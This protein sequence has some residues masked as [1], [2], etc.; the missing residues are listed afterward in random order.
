[1]VRCFFEHN[2]TA[3]GT[4][5]AH[6][7]ESTYRD[8]LNLYEL[9]NAIKMTIITVATL[10]IGLSFLFIETKEL[11]EARANLKWVQIWQTNLLWL[12][13]SPLPPFETAWQKSDSY[14]FPYRQWEPIW[15][16]QLIRK[17]KEIPVYIKIQIPKADGPPQ[18]KLPEL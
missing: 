3:Y 11:C 8:H 7:P 16:S 18:S 15:N 6:I 17:Y 12:M 2:T 5:M 1:M 4:N 10:L 14:A 9:W 13:S